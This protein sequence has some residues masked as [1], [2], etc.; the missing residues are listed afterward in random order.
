MK[1]YRI[2]DWARYETHET[3]KIKTLSWVPIPNKHD[4]LSFKRIAKREDATDIFTAWI[5]MLQVA[6]KGPQESRGLLCRDD[7]PLSPDDLEMMTGFNSG[8]FSKAYDVLSDANIGWIEC[9]KES[10]AM[11][12]D[13]PDEPGRWPI[14]GRKE[15]R[16]RTHQN[17]ASANADGGGDFGMLWSA[18]PKKVGKA[19]ALKAWQRSKHPPIQAVLARLESL[20][21]S[22]QWKK[23]GGQFIPHPATWINRGGWDDEVG[24]KVESKTAHYRDFDE[25]MREQGLTK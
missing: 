20:K 21:A 5:L 10:P 2:K 13:H 7:L 4:G 19:S 12:G 18:Y 23:D 6:S 25:Q 24:V 14:E 3:R 22:D 8:I 11:P 1:Y 17:E 15:G 16:N 9:Y